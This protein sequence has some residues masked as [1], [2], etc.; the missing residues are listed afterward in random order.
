MIHASR[1]LEEAEAFLTKAVP[2]DA[3][4]VQKGGV[5]AQA[6]QNGRMR[7]VISPFD[8]LDQIVPVRFVGQLRGVRLRSGHDQA[9]EMTVPEVLET[10]IEVA[11]I[12]P[13]SFI[14][15]NVGQ[16]EERQ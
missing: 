10:R 9:V 4:E 12:A 3:V 7:V 15:A 11:D 16:R 1:K 5:R 2:V 8:H 14:A 6:R 13:A